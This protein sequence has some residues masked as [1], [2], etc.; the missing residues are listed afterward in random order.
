MRLRAISAM[1]GAFFPA[2]VDELLC[3]QMV[4][5][6]HVDNVWLSHHASVHH[7]QVPLRPWQRGV[8]VCDNP[9]GLL[10]FNAAQLIPEEVAYLEYLF[11][12]LHL[13]TLPGAD[14]R[15]LP[16]LYFHQG[17]WRVAAAEYYRVPLSRRRCASA[18]RKHFTRRWVTSQAVAAEGL[19][20][21]RRA[22]PLFAGPGCSTTLYNVAQTAAPHI[23]L[24]AMESKLR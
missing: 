14:D 24:K 3:T 10:L 21:G 15:T 5:K 23:I 9:H 17:F 13:E 16:D 7:F 18:A 12:S 22:R 2:H 6:G 8:T 4:L 1:T 19:R 11:P 20:I